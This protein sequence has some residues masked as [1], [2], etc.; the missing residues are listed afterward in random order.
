[1][2]RERP[3]ISPDGAVA[4]LA[5]LVPAEASSPSIA[6]RV[7]DAD[8]SFTAV[9]VAATA[10]SESPAIRTAAAPWR[11]AAISCSRREA[12]RSPPSSTSTILPFTSA[13]AYP[14]PPRPDAA[15]PRRDPDHRGC[16]VAFERAAV[17]QPVASHD[18]RRGRRRQRLE[19][20]PGRDARDA[21]DGER[22]K[23]RAAV[24]PRTKPHGG[25]AVG[26]IARRARAA[27]RAGRPP[28]H[29]RRG[30]RGDVLGELVGVRRL[31]RRPAHPGGDGGA[32]GDRRRRRRFGGESASRETAEVAARAENARQQDDREQDAY[33]GSHREISPSAHHVR[34]CTRRVETD[35][36]GRGARS[37]GP[38][39]APRGRGTFN[40]RIDCQHVLA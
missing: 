33:S 26:Q 17:R 32:A 18:E 24:A 4:S 38:R 36:L 3:R 25:E 28:F 16:D 5:A 8:T 13:P 29:L 34:H 37:A 30:E 21:A 15:V 2:R 35:A 31:R 11:R 39:T 6:W 14:S 40:F 10:G 12:S 19:R 23:E 9:S 27:V 7:M 1:M 22:L 20:R